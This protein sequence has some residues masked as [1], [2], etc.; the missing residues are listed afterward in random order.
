MP[1]SQLMCG[2][3]AKIPAIDASTT[4]AGSDPYSP[5]SIPGVSDPDGQ[6][7]QP[8][9]TAGEDRWLRSADPGAAVELVFGGLAVGRLGSEGEALSLAD[10]V[11]LAAH[12]D[13]YTCGTAPAKPCA[14]AETT[15]IPSS[16]AAVITTDIDFFMAG[17][18]CY[19]HDT[20]HDKSPDFA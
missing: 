18:F 10:S 1:V 11:C 6:R 13:P 4:I 20:C 8:P 17:S 12:T 15:L 7:A 3:L 14:N 5:A 2:G 16:V 9:L 19:Y